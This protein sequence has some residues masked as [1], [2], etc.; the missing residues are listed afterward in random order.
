MPRSC[1]RAVYSSSFSCPQSRGHQN[2]LN[3]PHQPRRKNL[4]Q[5]RF[6]PREARGAQTFF[7]S[8]SPAAAFRFAGCGGASGRGHRSS[9]LLLRLARWLLTLKWLASVAACCVGGDGGQPLAGPAAP[10]T[11]LGCFRTEEVLLVTAF[12]LQLGPRRPLPAFPQT[13]VQGTRFFPQTLVWGIGLSG[14][15]QL[16]PLTS[17]RGTGPKSPQAAQAAARPLDGLIRRPVCDRRA[18]VL[19]CL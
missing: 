14:W 11:Q 8:S 2:H 6:S 3:L 12:Q 5:P 13:F 4:H 16:Q 15:L 18:P 7:F 9:L 17:P 19:H 1:P 10:R